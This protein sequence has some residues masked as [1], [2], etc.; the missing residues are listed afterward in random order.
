M[1]KSI[2]PK[3]N[4]LIKVFETLTNE[5]INKKLEISHNLAIKQFELNETILI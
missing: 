1:Y 4:K 2:N 3:N 5:Q